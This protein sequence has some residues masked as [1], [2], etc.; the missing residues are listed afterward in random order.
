MRNHKLERHTS[1]LPPYFLGFTNTGCQHLPGLL[2]ASSQLL[3][4]QM[5]RWEKSSKYLT[6]GDGEL[7]S[8][9][10]DNDRQTMNK[11]IE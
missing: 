4:I 9:W 11:I 8:S 3:S 5:Y 6:F 1:P 2:V 10:L 7:K